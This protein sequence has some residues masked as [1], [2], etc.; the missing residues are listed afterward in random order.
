MS[1]RN[2]SKDQKIYARRYHQSMKGKATS[3]R[4]RERRKAQRAQ[5]VL[6]LKRKPCTDCGGAFHP[7]AMDFDHVRGEKHKEI[8]VLVKNSAP[9]KTLMAEL[10]KCELVCANCHRVRTWERS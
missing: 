2:N 8:S 1:I 10:A 9:I 7:I 5:I 6:K 3:K 4:Y